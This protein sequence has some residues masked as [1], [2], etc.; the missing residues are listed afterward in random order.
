MLEEAGRICLAIKNL[1]MMLGYLERASQKKGASILGLTSLAD[2]F[3]LDERI[4]E[5]A[6]IVERAA[7]IDR[8]DPRVLLREAVLRRKRGQIKEAESRISRSH[9]ELGC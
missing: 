5:A 2:I 9:D 3:V 4:D 6:E 8:K 7:Q 1:D